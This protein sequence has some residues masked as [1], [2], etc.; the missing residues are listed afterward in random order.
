MATVLQLDLPWLTL[1]TKL[2]QEDAQGVLYRT[3]F[4]A[5]ALDNS[6]VQLVWLGKSSTDSSLF[7]LLVRCR[8]HG[9]SVHVERHADG[10]LQSDRLQSLWFVSLFVFVVTK[11]HSLFAGFISRNEFADVIKLILHDEN[12]KAQVNDAYIEELTAAMDF[13]KNGKIDVNEF[14][15]S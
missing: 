14:L 5:Y 10:S 4:D 15:G 9:G 1:R 12:E 3:M 13:D 11:A 2:V 7:L 6:K 8:Y